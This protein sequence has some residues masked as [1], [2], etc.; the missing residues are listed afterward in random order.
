MMHVSAFSR[1][2]HAARAPHLPALLSTGEGLMHAGAHGCGG[3]LLS[4]LP[5]PGDT[6][7]IDCMPTA[8][9]ALHGEMVSLP[10]WS[11]QSNLRREKERR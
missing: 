4:V 5:R 7:N 2:R 1:A 9:Q 3:S 8:R 6:C 10:P 11:L